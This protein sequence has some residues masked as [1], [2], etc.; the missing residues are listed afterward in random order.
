MEY[1]DEL[2]VRSQRGEG[3][4]G[5]KGRE[6]SAGERRMEIASVRG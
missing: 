1:R 6:R 5:R 2:I 3:G 4:K